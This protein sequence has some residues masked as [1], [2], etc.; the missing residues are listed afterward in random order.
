MIILIVNVNKSLLMEIP[1]CMKDIQIINLISDKVG[2]NNLFF[3][4][5]V[6]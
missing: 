6:T 1:E 4:Y 5:I 3:K 2:T